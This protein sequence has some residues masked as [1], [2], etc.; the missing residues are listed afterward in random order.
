MSPADRTPSFRRKVLFGAGAACWIFTSQVPVQLAN[1]IFVGVLGL[2][3]ALVGMLLAGPRFWDALFDPFVGAWSD[4]TRTRWGRRRPF[5]LAGAIGCFI[6]LNLL[7]LMPRGMSTNFYAW[8]G[9]IT[10][11]GVY[12]SFAIFSVPYEAMGYELSADYHQRSR[13]Q[14]VKALFASAAFLLVG[15]VLSL[16]QL[17]IFGDTLSGVRWVTF[18]ASLVFVLGAGLLPALL[19]K[20]ENTVA[21]APPLEFAA[22]VSALRCRPFAL[23]L[24]IKFLTGVGVTAVQ[25]LGFYIINYHIFRHDLKATAALMGAIATAS[26][27]LSFVA[28]PAVAWLSERLG[29]R[30]ALGVCTVC[31]AASSVSTLVTYTPVWPWLA[32]VSTLLFAPGQAAYEAILSS[33][34]ADS[35]DWHRASTNRDQAATFAALKLFT[36]KVTQSALLLGGGLVIAWAGFHAESGAAQSPG[37]VVRMRYL[38]ALVPAALA[39]GSLLLVRVY[40]LDETKMRALRSA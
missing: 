21:P 39:L 20:E 37:V 31:L 16:A 3:P 17:P 2:S 34:I 19:I 24:G 25:G 10:L 35:A 30:A 36:V 38:Y 22:F 32:L 6:A 27:A 1:P 12:T 18:G 26:A 13:V 8:Y 5:I 4:R 29:K 7:W 40:P 15:W 9:L 23:L 11:L 33:M 28:V 14:A